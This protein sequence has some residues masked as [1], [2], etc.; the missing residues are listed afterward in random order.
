MAFL[1]A[2]GIKPVEAGLF[3]LGLVASAFLIYLAAQGR[4]AE[5]GL[6]E[7]LG[8]VTGVYSVWYQARE[9][10]WLFP[11]GLSNSLVYM[12]IFWK[13][14][15]LGNFS[16]QVF[17]A[18]TEVAGWWWWIFR[19]H[20]RGTY[21]TSW[22]PW[23]Q[24]PLWLLVGGGITAGLVPLFRSWQ[25]PSP[26]LDAGTMAFSFVAQYQLARKYTDNWLTWVVVDAVSVGLFWSQH[27]YATAMLSVFYLALCPPGI[28]TW[29]ANSKIPDQ[30]IA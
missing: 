12:L 22:M 14:R 25:D 5:I 17:Y 16:L 9:N 6:W 4:A 10:I 27:L 30:A 23:Q 15:L 8:V 24:W 13:G 2:K 21:R 20:S 18:V 11:V 19:G 29:I 1:P 26:L 7:A 28:R 3:Y